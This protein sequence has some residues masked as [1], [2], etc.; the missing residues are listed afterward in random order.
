LFERRSAPIMVD[1]RA[2][3]FV[4]VGEQAPGA[5]LMAA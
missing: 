1:Y 3:V 2:G 4:K 5:R